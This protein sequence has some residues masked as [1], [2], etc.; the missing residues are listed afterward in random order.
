MFSMPV[1]N[2]EQGIVNFC[3]EIFQ[4]FESFDIELILVNDHSTDN[5]KSE[6]TRNLLSRKEL[7]IKLVDN[8]INLGHGPSTLIGIH[9][10]LMI[11]G[12][13][14][15][16]T[17]DGD[18]QFM[19]SDILRLVNYRR[20][21]NLDVVE[22]VRMNRQDP[23]FR[24]ISTITCRFLVFATSGRLPKDGNTC[25]RVYKPDSLRLLIK[26]IRA[27]F[28]VPNVLVAS[29]TRIYKLAF[30]QV[31]INS[32]PRRALN[33]LGSTWHQKFYRIPSRRYL[34]FCLKAISQWTLAFI[35]FRAKKFGSKIE[36]SANL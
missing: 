1:Y 33:P 8:D 31:E 17:V 12:V 21:L 4:T 15:I 34:T 22:G 30:A 26:Q 32:I 20:E 28:L 27:D 16:V 5:S 23:M 18:G 29:Y 25:L 24:K 13:E 6:I 14:S 10:A 2:E 35:K 36:N 3:L 9:H 11:P 7:K 19:A